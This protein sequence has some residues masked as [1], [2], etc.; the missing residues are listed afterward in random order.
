MDG[1]RAALGR[2]AIV[3][4]DST[5]PA[6]F[7]GN[8]L[9]EIYEPHTFISPHGSTA[10]GLGIPLALGAQAAR[11]DR[12]VMVIQGDGGFMLHATELATAVQYGLNMV[13]LLFNDSGYGILRRIQDRDYGGRRIG[14]DLHT[15][16]FV[17]F[18]E[19]FS[20][21]ALQVTELS[22]V[23][24]ALEQALSSGKPALIELRLPGPGLG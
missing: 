23:G 15:P 19:S 9:L 18:A 14:V 4:C 1:L 17:R 24:Q 6:Y 10:I 7:W 13:V 2:E 22:Q 11:P 12:Q 5:I 21:A 20:A 8:R 16:D 3:V